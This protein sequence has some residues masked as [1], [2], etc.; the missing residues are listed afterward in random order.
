MKIFVN[1][2][3]EKILQTAKFPI[4]QNMCEENNCFKD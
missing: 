3:C 1:K 4:L 2:G